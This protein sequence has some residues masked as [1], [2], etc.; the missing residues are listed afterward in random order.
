[1]EELPEIWDSFCVKIGGLVRQYMKG[2]C[3]C[4]VIAVVMESVHMLFKMHDMTVIA[5]NCYTVCFYLGVNFRYLKS[6]VQKI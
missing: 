3:L 2:K 6:E 4:C 5:R 1:M